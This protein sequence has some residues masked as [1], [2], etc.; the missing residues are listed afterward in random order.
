M[1]KIFISGPMRNIEGF[2]A[3]AF[4]NAK[5]YLGVTFGH[6]LEE[7]YDPIEVHKDEYNVHLSELT[8][9]EDV[10]MFMDTQDFFRRSLQWII[11]EATGMYMLSGWEFSDGATTEH[12]VATYIGLPITYEDDIKGLR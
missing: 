7:I 11:W 6:I 3:T 4:Q 10:G 1:S 8:G 5:E 2:N 9:K 12:R